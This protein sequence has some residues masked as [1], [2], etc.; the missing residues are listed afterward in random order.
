MSL[1]MMDGEP[2]C[3]HC[4][5]LADAYLCPRCLRSGFTPTYRIDTCIACS[6][7][8]RVPWGSPGNVTCGQSACTKEAVDRMC[9]YLIGIKEGQRDQ[10]GTVSSR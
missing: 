8:F 6:R 3:L 1:E 10:I 4:G 2:K 9:G 7:S 5:N